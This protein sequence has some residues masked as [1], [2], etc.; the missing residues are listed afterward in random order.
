MG[1]PSGQHPSYDFGHEECKNATGFPPSSVS[2]LLLTFLSFTNSI[3]V[4][5][6]CIKSGTASFKSSVNID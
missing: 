1:W 3:H 2:L 4:R 5:E 6:T